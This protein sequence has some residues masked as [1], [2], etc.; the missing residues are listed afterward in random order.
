M[1][2]ELSRGGSKAFRTSVGTGVIHIFHGHPH[3][4]SVDAGAGRGTAQGA[5]RR[6]SPAAGMGRVLP[7]AALLALALSLAACTVTGSGGETPEPARPADEV[8]LPGVRD[9]EVQ[10][11][12]VRIGVISRREGE[13]A[14][15]GTRLALRR[16]DDRV[17]GMPV[18]V[19]ALT[20]PSSLTALAQA[21]EEL[22]SAHR[23]HGLVV[24]L[25]P[26]RAAVA[27]T[28]AQAAATPIF[29]VVDPAAA[30]PGFGFVARPSL[31]DQ[32]RA[33]AR[34][35]RDLGADQAAVIYDVASFSQRTLARAFAQA[36]IDLGGAVS[37]VDPVPS[38]GSEAAGDGNLAA[39]LAAAAEGQPDVLLLA[40]PGEAAVQAV[41]MAAEAGLTI[42]VL[43]APDWPG[44]ALAL[45]AQAAGV[46]L[47]YPATFYPGREAAET[48]AFVA[49]YREAY[50]EEPTPGTA[51]A[52]D[53]AEMLMSA[54]EAAAAAGRFDPQ[55]AAATRRAVMDALHELRDF[56]G[57]TG[58]YTSSADV[59]ARRSVVLLRL[60]PGSDEAGLQLA[61]E[62]SP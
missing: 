25:D 35:A 18:E 49:A 46:E 23:V 58:I 47:I 28:V 38:P 59:A 31:S 32:G 4:N 10:E 14:E 53:A 13:D 7:A 34:Y 43:G 15:R 51:L 1:R 3:P 57:A 19:V 55:D 61:R 48:A 30:P 44:A 33:L 22:I 11:P 54:V 6:P 45:A 26:Q 62:I 8:T 41:V 24:D 21:V 17:A 42:P 16:R 40:L 9:V 37:T 39:R 12:V 27:A 20:G 60:T 36:F 50:E 2:K 29:H 56:R 52:Y 5:G